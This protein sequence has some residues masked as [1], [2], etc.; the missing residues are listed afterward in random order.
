MHSN[1]FNV[2]SYS[3]P[4]DWLWCSWTLLHSPQCRHMSQHP[5][6]QLFQCTNCHHSSETF[7]QS[8]EPVQGEM[9]TVTQKQIVF[10]NVSLFERSLSYR[11]PIVGPVSFWKRYSI[12]QHA[13][14]TQGLAD[15]GSDDRSTVCQ[16]R[17]L[18]RR[19]KCKVKN[20]L[21][22][23]ETGKVF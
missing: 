17:G 4:P 19:K 18:C 2:G 21:E 6:G 12:Q 22:E 8:V 15:A 7:A 11:F 10:M 3:G 9:T 13:R 23:Q 14:N 1:F 16:E 5:L 20:T